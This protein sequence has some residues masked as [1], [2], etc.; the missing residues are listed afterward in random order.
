MDKHELAEI[1]ARDDDV[2]HLKSHADDER[3]V[4]EVHVIGWA[5]TRKFEPAGMLV[6]L[7]IVI[8]AVES[9]GVAQP[10]NSVHQRPRADDG[11]QRQHKMEAEVRA[12]RLVVIQKKSDGE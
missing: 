11:K 12:L 7:R 4:G 2:G 10:E 6:R 5:A 3:E 1:A 8:I 9:M